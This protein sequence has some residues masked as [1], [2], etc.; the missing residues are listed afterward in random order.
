MPTPAG[1]ADP[2]SSDGKPRLLG[3]CPLGED[4]GYRQWD[5]RMSDDSFDGKLDYSALQQSRATSGW[6]L[7]AVAFQ[8][9]PSACVPTIARWSRYF[10]RR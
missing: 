10:M 6:C 2:A 3:L 8:F 5:L 9:L 7:L 1:D 4:R